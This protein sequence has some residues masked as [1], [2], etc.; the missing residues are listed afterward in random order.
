[1]NFATAD[2]TATTGD[3]DYVA[4]SGTLVFAPGQTSKS[5]PV[6]VKGDKKKESNETFFVNL[7]GATNATIAGFRGVGEILNDDPR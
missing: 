7:T 3:G 2:G 6:T 5:I 4:K 1:M